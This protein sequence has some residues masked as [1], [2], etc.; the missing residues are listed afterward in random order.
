MEAIQIHSINHL[1]E[2]LKNADEPLEFFIAMNFGT[3]SSKTITC[4]DELDDNGEYKLEILNQID[5]TVQILSIDELDK[6]TNI[7]EAIKKG[8]FYVFI[9]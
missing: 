9:D 2:T 3:R 5:D 4:A 6:E 7:P 8:S 1:V